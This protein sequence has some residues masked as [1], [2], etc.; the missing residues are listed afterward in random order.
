MRITGVRLGFLRAPLRVPFRTA[1]RTVSQVED[2]VVLL[3]TDA[4][5]VGHGSAPSTPV[6]TGDT[7]ASIIAAIRG[8][9]AGTVT[10]REVADLAGNCRAVATALEGN[11][12]AKAAIEIALHDLAAQQAGLPLYR[13]LGGTA[14]QVPETDLTI[15]VNDADTMIADARDAIARGYRALKIKVGKTPETDLARIRAIHAAV[16]ADA[17]LRLDAN[18]GWTAD[19]A[20]D[21]LGTLEADGLAFDL[22]EQPVPAIDVDGLARITRA[23][24]TPVMA[25]ESVFS[26]THAARVIARGAAD[27]LNV[28]LMK[29]A[30]LT[31]ALRIADLAGAAG[32]PCMIGCMIESSIGIAAA[33]HLAAARP[34]AITRTDLDTPS[35]CRVDPVHGNVRF[36]GP[37]ITI[38]D[39]P[40][41]GITALD[42]FAPLAP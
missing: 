28:K 26:P 7:H 20:I 19:L 2:V 30:G 32:V 15:S 14:A 27:I 24:R 6:I 3:D 18:Q 4:G 11:P 37:S 12:S 23:V 35:L 5:L 41:L 17:V 25:D 8:T 42:G 38:D 10:G 33:A 1:L 29:A 39:A 31:G 36:D 13:L 22:L 16:G 40:G 9:L 34:Q 21:L